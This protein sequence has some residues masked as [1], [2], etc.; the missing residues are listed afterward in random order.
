MS[1]FHLQARLELFL[2]SSVV[3]ALWVQKKFDW[4][5]N[6]R[7]LILYISI[8]Y[9]ESTENSTISCIFERLTY[10]FDLPRLFWLFGPNVCTTTTYVPS[11]WSGLGL[12]QKIRSVISN[13]EACFKLV[14]KH[15]LSKPTHLHVNQDYYELW[16]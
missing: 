13:S 4:I 14:Q 1:L 10:L 15:S 12:G 6:L 5:L 11:T 3:L 8:F 16:R 7:L 2:L 9:Y